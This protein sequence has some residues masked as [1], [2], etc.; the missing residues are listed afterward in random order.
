M[1]QA[2]NVVVAQLDKKKKKKKKILI[3]WN[4]MFS[5]RF[6][7]GSRSSQFQ[8]VIPSCFFKMNFKILVP[9]LSSRTDLRE[10]VREGVDWLHLV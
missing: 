5:T 8:P 4:S 6:K 2:R 1:L 3:G 10:I 7:E 9:E